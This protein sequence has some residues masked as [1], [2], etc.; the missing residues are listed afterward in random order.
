MFSPRSDITV[1]ESKTKQW[2]SI[3]LP[4]IMFAVTVPT[5]ELINDKHPAIAL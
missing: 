1:N 3:T 2:L 5:L 4:D